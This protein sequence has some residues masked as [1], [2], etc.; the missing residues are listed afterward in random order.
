M[1]FFAKLMALINVPMNAVGKSL[2]GFIGIVPGWLSNSIISAILGAI[3]ILIFKHTSNQKTIGKLKDAIKVN[4][5]ALK[6]FK[7]NLSV[8]FSSIGGL[9]KTSLIRLVYTLLPVTV[10]VIP[11]CLIC[12][13]M[14]PWYQARPLLTGE[15]AEVIVRLTGSEY[16]SL[17]RVT[18]S[19]N[20]AFEI[21]IA[22]FKIPSKR[23]MIWTIK[24]GQEGLHKLNFNID[25]QIYEKELAVGMGFMRVSEKRPGLKF[26]E[27]LFHPVEKP[28][29]KDSLVQS[30][31]IEYPERISYTSGSDWWII[32][33]LIVS[34][35]TGFILMPVFKVK[36]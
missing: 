26:T 30:I 25:G 7:D 23:E 33:L 22:G 18:L 9:F 34:V 14:G 28:F 19:K 3:A 5:F 6:L 1:S 32:Y 2:F 10:M 16:D 13:Q 4:M 21:K 36:I 20:N 31:I 11:F 12:S 35:L 29:S 15:E 24:A 17:P 8:T 27:I